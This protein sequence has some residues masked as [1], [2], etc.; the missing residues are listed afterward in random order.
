M[1]K[2][3]HQKYLDY[4]QKYYLLKMQFGGGNNLLAKVTSLKDKVT[5][6]VDKI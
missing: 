5:A 1:T 2:Y 4:K 3:Y 6:K